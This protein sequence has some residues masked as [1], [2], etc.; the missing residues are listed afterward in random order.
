MISREFLFLLV[1]DVTMAIGVAELYDIMTLISCGKTLT[2][3]SLTF[4]DVQSLNVL[5]VLL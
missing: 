3:I 1:A 4:I 5:N 2:L